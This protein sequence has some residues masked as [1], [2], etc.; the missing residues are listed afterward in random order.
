MARNN[1]GNGIS[2]KGIVDLAERIKRKIR[3]NMLDTA[4]RVGDSTRRPC[5]ISKCELERWKSWTAANEL[6]E[7]WRWCRTDP[8]LDCVGVSPPNHG[9]EIREKNDIGR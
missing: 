5:R 4:G 8:D 3:E 2:D 7:K 9:I 1:Y 6:L